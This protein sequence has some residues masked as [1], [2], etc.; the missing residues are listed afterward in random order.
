MSNSLLDVLI[1][2]DAFFATV[3]K[4]KE[5]L[6][7]PALIVLVGG[8][9]GAATAFFV[10]RPT[11]QMMDGISPG[12]GA[13]TIVM[14]LIVGF[15]SVFIS[16]TF[17]AEIFFITSMILR[18][19]LIPSFNREFIG[20]ILGLSGIVLLIVTSLVQ[21]NA[22]AKQ[23]TFSILLSLLS[24]LAFIAIIVSIFIYLSNERFLRPLEFIGYGY[25][26]Q[27]I[28]SFISLIAAF[29]YI[30]RITVPVLTKSALEDPTAIEAA[31]KALIYDP[32]M[33]EY[34]QITTLVAIV[35]MLWSAH[36]WIFSMKHA[37]ILPIRDAAICVGIP[38]VLYVLYLTYKLGVM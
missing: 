18:K 15:L 6:K 20:S 4:E 29:T 3:T 37:R 33:V 23:D 2:P 19:E 16:W 26:P 9:I 1:Q 27:I 22:T 21:K 5:N 34:T 12:W 35:F 11:A 25:L 7:I 8:I 10:S 14:A 32:A 17:L 24:L 13:I 31:V 30:P 38:V 28:G 36:I